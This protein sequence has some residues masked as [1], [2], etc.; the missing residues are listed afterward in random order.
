MYDDE[1]RGKLA[2]WGEEKRQKRDELNAEIG[3]IRKKIKRLQE[4]MAKLKDERKK[5]TR[6]LANGIT[7]EKR[8]AWKDP[9]VCK[10]E[11]YKDWIVEWIQEDEFHN[12]R[13]LGEISKV[14]TRTIR[15]ILNGH[16]YYTTMTTTDR[17]LTAINCEWVV[18]TLAVFPNPRVRG[19][20]PSQYYEE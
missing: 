15:D 17:L 20:P 9:L 14:S 1:Y 10:S 2:D 3:N 6:D 19:R 16:R 5:L 4:S 11:D 18:D 12:V 13:L 8:G 7:F